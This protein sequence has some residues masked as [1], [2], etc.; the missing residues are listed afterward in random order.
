M[1]FDPT[2][3]IAPGLNILSS[4]AGN[5]ASQGD[6]DEYQR[7]M[8]ALAREYGSVDA[9]TLDAL[10]ARTANSTLGGMQS[11]F[12]NTGARNAAIQA[13]I[14]EGL[15]GG[16]TL[17][18]QLS[19]ANAQRAAGQA[20]RQASQSALQSAASRGT[21]GGAATLQAQLLGGSQGADR[22]AQ[23]G[24]QGAA[25]ARRNAL[26]SLAQ[27]GSMAGQAEQADSGRELA[28]RQSLDAMARFNAGQAAEADRFNSG[29]QQ[30]N[31]QNRV[32]VSDR[33]AQ[34]TGVRAET[35]QQRAR[36]TREMLGGFGQAAGQAG[37]AAYTYGREG[38]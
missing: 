38:K 35:A 5:I 2:M 11:D 18:T 10:Q 25:D 15:S 22:A 4:I 7:Q 28:R 30:Q 17:E 6:E 34:G 32:Q 33:K 16:N 23:V 19:Q 27:G 36:R 14:N 20:T 12:G 8:E 24:L 31:F 1:A 26:Q 37:A 9:P 21:G 3:L 29:L 13:L